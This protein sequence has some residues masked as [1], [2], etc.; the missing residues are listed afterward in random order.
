MSELEAIIE[1]IGNDIT[2]NQT[3][4]FNNEMIGCIAMYS[5][6]RHLD[7]L[8]TAKA[9]LILPIAFHN[10]VVSYIG[11]A[12]TEIKSI[13]QLLLRK[14]DLLANFN[15]RFYSLL[16]VSVNCI[17]ILVALKFVSV[18]SEGTINVLKDKNFIPSREKKVIGSR[19]SRI[20][21]SASQIA[22]LF[23]DHVENLY[24]QLRV[25]L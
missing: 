22:K 4:I 16:E 11:R 8:S 21:D 19:A 2:L 13:E 20:I 12:N 25:K 9:M 1:T 23:D 6:I 24:L 5:V 10:Q 17:A 14:P 15:G 7:S 3:N 18:N